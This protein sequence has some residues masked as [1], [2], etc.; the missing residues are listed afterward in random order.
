MLETLEN[1]ILMARVLGIDVSH[2]QGTINWPSVAAAGKQFAFEKATESTSY[3]DPTMDTNVSGGKAAGLLMGVYHF[4][5]PDTS[6]NDAV[7]EATHF[8]NGGGKYMT[9]GY[10]HPV[11]DLEAGADLGKAAL[12]QWVNSFCAT[13]KSLAG[14]DPLIYCNTNYAAN[15]V[16]SSV[17]AHDLWIANWSTSYGDPTTT[18]SPPTGV[19][20]GT[21][22]F[23]QHTSSGAVA[24]IAGRVDLDVYNGDLATLKKNFQ[25]GYVPPAVNGT[26]TSFLYEDR[27][28]D[29]VVDTGEPML[30]G[31]T[32][33]I[34]SNNNGALDTSE[35]RT[36]TDASGKYTFSV[37]PGTYLVR[38]VLPSNWYQTKPT[39][40]TGRS[41]TVIAGQ[42]ATPLPFGSAKYASI[43]GVV[44]RDSNSNKTRDTG[45]TGLANWVVYL[46]SNNNGKRD[47]GEKSATTI[48]ST[49][50]WSF[51]KLKTGSYI[52]RIVQKS[53]FTRTTPT[54]GSFSHR[55]VS[56]QSITTDLFGER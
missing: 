8:V 5:R 32:V 30:G 28:G 31:R 50:R 38:Q 35:K 54:G 24:G 25:I 22:D 51:T 1:R 56:G 21:W 14:V 12:S 16:D 47:T 49:G 39:P 45:E 10:L 53:G 20:G 9:A 27:D 55:L 43:S 52:V 41:V 44:F 40:G 34:D 6:A 33:Y 37:A 19:W 26:I 46:D 3:V 29:A 42:T 11:L 4:A 48:D 13:V 7:N 2:W 15:Y 18:G 23:W 17:S 36:T